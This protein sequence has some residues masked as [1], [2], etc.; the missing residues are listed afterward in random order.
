MMAV[1]FAVT[2]VGLRCS[3]GQDGPRALAAVR[4]GI[5]RLAEW[6]APGS[7]GEDSV[8]VAAA[9]VYP[10]LG[11]LGWTEKFADLATQPL[12]EALASAE[13]GDIA[14]SASQA[15][16]GLF[17]SLPARDRAGVDPDDAGEF[18]RVLEERDL[19][20]FPVPHQTLVR[21]GHASVLLAAR[22]AVTAMAEEGLHFCVVGGVDSLLHTGHLAALEEQRRLKS[23]D[24]PVGLF[25]GEAGAFFV[26]EPVE[27]ARAR[28]AKPLAILAP[29]A[30]EMESDPSDDSGPNRGRAMA[31]VLRKALARGGCQPAVIT[32]LLVDL[33]GERWRFVE[34][35]LAQDPA[36]AELPP[37]RAM[38][39]PADSLGDVGAATG[40]AHVALASLALRGGHTRGSAVLIANSSDTGERAAACLRA[41][42]AG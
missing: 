19:F 23:G 24:C 35:A 1:E 6:P 12:L 22:Q 39:Y 5:S 2:G 25:P 38:W 21:R 42:T 27:S 3:V 9:A 18:E 16:W 8:A 13:L 36:L 28:G 15:R 30:A 14:S 40:A 4:A 37:D 10:D 32:K 26:L 29:V 31:S 20:P 7:G 41:A 17:L 11:D 34:W 33:N